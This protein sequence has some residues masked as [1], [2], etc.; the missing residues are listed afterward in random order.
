MTSATL[1][2]SAKLG[3]T[4]ARR[5]ALVHHWLVTRRGGE[6]CLEALASLLP[7]ADLFTLVHDPDACPVP[8]G[9]GTVTTSALQR[10]GF[11]RRHFRAFLPLFPRLYGG[12][13]LSGYDLVLS[14]DASLAKT[15]KVPQ[16]CL[17]VCYCYSP[18]RYA[19]DLSELYLE[20]SVPALARPLA[21]ALLAGV[22]RADHRAAQR[23]DHF[24]A[25]S[26]TVA[27]R[28]ERCYGRSSKVIY[29]PTDIEF[30]R[31]DETEARPHQAGGDSRPYLLLG[32]A[33]PYKRFDDAVNACRTLGRPLIVAGG[34][35]GFDQL[36][37]LAGPQT[38]FIPRPT[39][40]EV[41]GMYQRCRALI[42]PGEEDFG[43]VPV[44]AMACGRP[45]IALGRGGATETIVHEQ[46]GILTT[47]SGAEVLLEGIRRFEA[48]ERHFEPSAAVARATRFS[49]ESH[50]R[51]MGRFLGDLQISG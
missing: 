19:W 31:P 37:D 16:D 38:T 48:W 35:P 45:V 40:A 25:I 11:G 14:S 49:L 12:L 1:D 50:R 26:R 15:V 21:R 23:V 42:F 10:W 5:I 29:P 32:Q 30:F 44:E 34:G 28:I 7:G 22:R 2:E 4:S 39:D 20:R 8:P 33:V 9:L 13:D 41:R 47:S 46:T 24:V 51:A 3:V 27:E 18:V 6:R 43:L 36:R 17:H